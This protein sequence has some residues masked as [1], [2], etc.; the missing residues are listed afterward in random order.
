MPSAD[1][2]RIAK[3]TMMLYFR[4]ILTMVVTIYTSRVILTTLGV[5]DYGIFNVVGG[6]VSM[7]AVLNSS[8]SAATSRFLIFELGRKDYPQLKKVFNASLASHIAIALAVL[9]IAE[10]VGLWFLTHKMVIP[11]GRMDAALWAYQF[12]VLATLVTLTQVPYTALIIAHEKMKIYA[13]MSFL[14]VSLKLVIVYFLKVGTYDKLKLYATLFFAVSLI[15]A[16][17]YRFYCNRKYP[18]SL[19]SFHW[20]KSLYKK[21]FTFSICELYGGFA[22]ISMGQGTNI[23]LNIFFGPAVNAARGVAQNISNIIAR[24]S[25]NFMTAVKPQIVKL[26]AE[27][28]ISQMMKMVFSASKYSFFLLFFLS[29]PL[30]LET[31]IVLK[32]WLKTVPEYSEIFCRLVLINNLILATANP[33][34]YAFHAV[35]NVKITNLVCGSLFYLV[36]LGSY[37]FLKFGYPPQIVFVITIAVTLLVHVVRLFLLKKFIS[38]SLMSYFK[39]VVMIILLVVL[40]SSIIPIVV[41]LN[42]EPGFIRFLTVGSTCV[43]TVSASIYFIG[44]D[45]NT[46]KYVIQKIVSTV[47]KTMRKKA[48][49][50]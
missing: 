36:I 30:L 3:N 20:D 47:Q 5:V 41:F 35:G 25:I 10:T 26:Y 39:E 1:N 28:K 48:K 13:Y 44:I 14:E 46:R 31:D 23:L 21:L 27:N 11:E 40:V 8:M 19:I 12:S 38:Y 4:M 17:A 24:F 29:L 7:F 6:F 50:K 43:V 49:A 33:F 15:N 37:V 32:T 16:L 18:E 34:I 9:L 42:M 22:V 45:R 2:K